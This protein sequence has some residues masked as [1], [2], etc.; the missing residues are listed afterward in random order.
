MIFQ[1][2]SWDSFWR[3][4]QEL[5]PIHWQELALNKDKISLAIDEPRFRKIY[6][7]GLLLIVGARQEVRL[8]GYFVAMILPHIHYKD[9]GNMAFTDMYYIHPEFRK[10][11]AG[12]K[13]FLAVERIFKAKGVVKAYIS[14]KVHQDNSA[15]FEKL[16]WHFSDKSYTKMIGA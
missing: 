1:I 2:E 9:A 11:G 4:G 12:V 14:S 6:E 3:D 10:G 7:D 8:V 16:G 5:F 15:L 13:M